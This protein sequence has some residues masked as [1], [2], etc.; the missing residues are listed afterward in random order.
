MQATTLAPAAGAILA[1]PPLAAD[2][3]LSPLVANLETNPA[4]VSALIDSPVVNEVLNNPAVVAGLAQDP[5]CALMLIATDSVHRDHQNAHS[6]LQSAIY[7]LLGGHWLPR[8]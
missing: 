1:N 8:H 3:A 2:I 6:N 7:S 5:S 4:A